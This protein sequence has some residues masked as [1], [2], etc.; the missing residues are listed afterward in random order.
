MFGKSFTSATQQAL[1]G[2]Q[3]LV[4]GEMAMSWEHGRYVYPF[5]ISLVLFGLGTRSFSF[6]GGEK[7]KAGHPPV[8]ATL[9]LAFPKENAK[10]HGVVN[11][12]VDLPDF[13]RLASVE[14]LL[15]GRPLSGPIAVQPFSYTWNTAFAW[16]GP[17]TIHAI[18]RDAQGAL[19]A[20]SNV[21]HFSIANGSGSIRLI[22]PD[23][24]K[25]LSGKI[26]WA[27]EADRPF[28]PGEMAKLG[29]PGAA[30]QAKPI[31]AIL[32]FVDGKLIHPPFH[33][34]RQTSLE[35]NTTQWPD[36]PHELFASAYSS[37]PGLPPVAMVRIPVTFNNGHRLR[38]LRPQFADVFLL[39]GQ[40]VDLAP[41]FVFTDNKEEPLS[42]G[43]TFKSAAA[44]IASVDATGRVKGIAPGA[45]DIILSARGY[46][47]TTRVTVTK[48][49]EVPHFARDGAILTRYDPK[50]SLWVRSLFGLGPQEL[51][52]TPELAKAAH[53]AA[54][55]ALTTGFYLNPADGGKPPDFE[56]WQKGWIPWWESIERVAK[57][58]QFSL[59]L[60]GDDIAR[61][62]SEL[63][64]SVTNPWAAKALQCAFAKA[65]DSK[66]VICVEMVDEV[67]FLW[68]NTPLPK[69]GRWKKRKTPVGDDAFSK[70]MTMINEVPDRPPLS[71]PTGGTSGPIAAENW[72]G[73]PAMANYAS[74][75]WT[76]WDWRRAYPES[77][78]LPQD[79]E[80]MDRSVLGY[81]RVLQRDRPMIL[82][83][84]MAGPMYAKQGEGA[85]YT[86]GKDKQE[87]QGV[88][89]KACA[90][91]AM[92]AAAR[93]MSGVRVYHFDSKDWKSERRKAKVGQGN[94]Q[95]G[96]DPFETGTERWQSLASAF[97]LIEILEPFLL[98]PP[99]HALHLGPNV[100]TGAKHGPESRLLI[101]VNL[102][103]AAEP[104]HVDLRPY[105]Y[106]DDLPLIRYHLVGATLW[107][108]RP[109]SAQFDVLT[110]EAGEA[111]VW[112]FRPL[113]KDPAEDVIPPSVRLLAPQAN[114]T[115]VGQVKVTADASDETKLDRVEFY[116]DGRKAAVSRKAPYSWAL[117][118]ENVKPGIWH[119]IS[120]I[121]HDASGNTSEAR[122]V[123]QM[124]APP[125]NSK[126]PAEN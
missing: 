14:Y 19:I 96:S 107:T 36:G 111:V 35:L 24:A 80:G 25:P 93:G 40:T 86:P 17:A 27:V 18:A 30:S 117:D 47:A 7:E 54:I 45:T 98:Q 34:R 6:Q 16:D 119:C 62:N 49:T 55:N 43:V 126:N 88:S 90:A 15:N 77:T 89:A 103:E 66:R 46:Q 28:S 122:T 68:G 42:S 61:T 4:I 92:Y 84:S 70:L 67:S 56:T 105:R 97:R 78:S 108:D 22:A 83:S 102:S 100:V 120:A 29:R 71:W 12:M 79:R 1:S 57:E 31:E 109:R 10:V 82:L 69:D 123:V 121:A 13:P 114:S 48:S 85:V 99:M 91:Q 37:E 33:G 104:V 101:A 60:T 8:R 3:N 87:A 20:K 23:P 65:R 116:I 73:N 32:L 63:A 124:K 118:T 75:F 81:Y 112:L 64:N 44:S 113:P 59:V 58:N 115:L 39:P 2:I 11:L 41:R 21:V 95:T 5:F 26:K 9:T 74:L 52:H 50:R 72:M 53:A 76:Y 110:L 106:A 94:L 38:D 51:K 125:L